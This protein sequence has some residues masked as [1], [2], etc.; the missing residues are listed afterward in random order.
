M[1]FRDPALDN[2][3][4]LSPP[5][6]APFDTAPYDLVGHFIHGVS[7]IVMG[8][9]TVI[10]PKLVCT[11]GHVGVGIPLGSTFRVL[12][13]GG[14]LEYILTEAFP[15][16][17][18]SDAMY[19]RTN[20][21][22]P[23]WATMWN[24]E[25]WSP[26]TNWL[27]AVAGGLGRGAYQIDGEGF[28]WYEWGD[29][30]TFAWRWGVTRPDNLDLGA[31]HPVAINRFRLTNDPECFGVAQGDSGGGCFIDAGPGGA[32][33]YLGPL[34]SPGTDGKTFFDSTPAHPD[35]ISHGFGADIV[36]NDLAQI[37]ALNEGTFPEP[38]EPPE[39]EPAP[40][41]PASQKTNVIAPCACMDTTQAPYRITDHG[42][43]VPGDPALACFR[44][45]VACPVLEGDP[46]DAE[47][48]YDPNDQV[49][50][51]DQRGVGNFFNCLLATA[52][53][54]SPGVRPDAWRLIEI[55]YI[56][57]NFLTWGTHADWLELDGQADKAGA[58]AL[59]A[60]EMLTLEFDK[61]ERQQ[62]QTEP[63]TVLTR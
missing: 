33:L 56:F 23:K 19:F 6:Q 48:T 12:M 30:S 51:T 31:L 47:A 36:I 1:L 32:W 24:M 13:A 46:W 25:A 17:S 27:F 15:S 45:R 58:A 37:A 44:Y 62:R 11:A 49:Y 41:P 8:P 38:P 60:F 16:Q 22:F 3:H 29:A 55:P 40:S 14:W 59:R 34:T 50:Y 2:S 10:G 26:D 52:A 39:P 5:T 35:F 43:R 63:W 54:E 53:G 28:E 61:V 18:G 7:G 20:G 21:S 42:V 4:N 9:G 57:Q